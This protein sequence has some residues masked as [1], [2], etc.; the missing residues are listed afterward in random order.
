[1][2]MIHLRPP[3]REKLIHCFPPYSVL[4]P[5]QTQ[6][7][8]A[9]KQ[10]FDLNLSQKDDY[11]H[12]QQNS[13]QKVVYFHLHLHSTLTKPQHDEVNAFLLQ[14]PHYFPYIHSLNFHYDQ[15]PHFPPTF[16]A[17]K[18]MKYFDFT[19]TGTVTFPDDLFVKMRELERFSTSDTILTALPLSLASLPYLRVIQI[20]LDWRTYP[21]LREKI[22][23]PSNYGEFK[24]LCHH[25]IPITGDRWVVDDFRFFDIRQKEEKKILQ[26]QANRRDLVTKALYSSDQLTSDEIDFL[27][28]YCEPDQQDCIER[29]LPANHPLVRRF[30]GHKT[31][32]IGKMF[33]ILR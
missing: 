21:E 18:S 16:R 17:L 28:K 29:A 15:M 20:D 3:Q 19:G 26:F 7:L 10:Y 31:L 1:M 27:A 30:M 11:F 33:L 24:A 32:S 25:F 6:F 23:L 22:R 13:F 4:H 12:L 14:I 9:M 8:L 5:D 2:L